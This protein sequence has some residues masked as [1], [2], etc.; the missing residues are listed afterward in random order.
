MNYKIKI[1]N[2]M[3]I[4]SLYF[5]DPTGMLSSLQASS[6]ARERHSQRIKDR[7]QE[8]FKL[9]TK[10]DK[11][12]ADEEQTALK[13]IKSGIDLN[14]KSNRF[15]RTL[16]FGAVRG[17]HWNI[18]K[19]LLKKGA[20]VNA[21]DID[22]NTSLHYVLSW[23]RE[24]IIQEDFQKI[25]KATDTI[26]LLIETKNIDLNAI[27]KDGYTP[28][29]YIIG[30]IIMGAALKT[31]EVALM[32]TFTITERLIAKGASSDR[33]PNKFGEDDEITRDSVILIKKWIEL[34][35]VNRKR[36]E[37]LELEQCIFIDLKKVA[38]QLESSLIKRVVHT[39]IDRK[40]RA[41]EL[42]ELLKKDQLNVDNG[43]KALELIKEGVDLDAIDMSADSK[44]SHHK[45]S[46]TEVSEDKSKL[47]GTL[48]HLAA[49]AGYQDIVKALLD[50]G[51][52][53]NLRD[54]NRNT[55]LHWAIDLFNRAVN[56]EE[57]V[58]KKIEEAMNTIDVL[59]K[60]ANIDLNAANENS[61]TLLDFMG[62]AIVN[63]VFKG[64][65]AGLK[66]TF[67][68]IKK[69]IVQGA[70]KTNLGSI[71]ESPWSAVDAMAL[72][73]YTHKTRRSI[74]LTK[75]RK[76]IICD[77]INRVIMEWIELKKNNPKINQ[78]G[79]FT[80]ATNQREKSII[81]RLEKLSKKNA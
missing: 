30:T 79:R 25:R 39:W 43:Q 45:V 50:Q 2:T 12:S 11:L 73:K 64:N 55:P 24:I 44:I 35:E 49:G 62:K 20:D 5:A 60:V 32:K 6:D 15:K 46:D 33:L 14:A 4:G 27:N 22:K 74:H 17:Y 58:A 3:L 21:C 10:K 75:D 9:L 67:M 1:L 29:D 56:Q 51:M 26:D 16:L 7:T 18:V 77:S 48:L 36:C 38:D 65:T 69:L 61:N 8:L 34:N 66:N 68:I 54:A 13:L 81:E 76:E 40:M 28:L 53:V 42:F 52:D 19:A 72:H 59:I 71:S 23:F 47:R 80:K 63:A 31:D 70:S 41:K 37:Q 57:E 78:I